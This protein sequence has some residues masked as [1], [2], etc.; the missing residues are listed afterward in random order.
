M[1]REYTLYEGLHKYLELCACICRAL[2]TNVCS[3][4]HVY[5]ERCTPF[6]CIRGAQVLIVFC[7]NVCSTAHV[8]VERCTP[9]YVHTG[10][11]SAYSVVHVCL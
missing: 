3:T 7:T 10:C 8:Y 1:W 4:A 9:F 5:V 11:T 2:C 6:M